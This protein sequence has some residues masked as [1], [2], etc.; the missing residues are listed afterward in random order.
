[1]ADRV[2][3]AVDRGQPA[4]LHPPIDLPMRE[5]DDDQLDPGR[6]AVLMTGEPAQPAL[7]N[8][9]LQFTTTTVV[10]FNLTIHPPNIAAKPAQ[11]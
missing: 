7:Q 3:A 5:A 2:D 9:R 4:G 6:D 1:M 8:V 11:V 10:N